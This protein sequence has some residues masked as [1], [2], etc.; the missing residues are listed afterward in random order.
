MQFVDLNDL[1]LI[2]Y[3]ELIRLHFLENKD[4][5]LLS[6]AEKNDIS[7]KIQEKLGDTY[8]EEVF[9]YEDK[10]LVAID[11]KFTEGR[12][13]KELVLL[14]ALCYVNNMDLNEYFT[15]KIQEI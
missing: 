9:K 13:F 2:S 14:L 10:K 6:S 5:D 15:L 11:Y 12:S 7:N 4:R 1:G 8:L 3:N